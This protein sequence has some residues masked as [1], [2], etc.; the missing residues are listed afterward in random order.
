MGPPLGANSLVNALQLFGTICS[1]DSHLG[2]LI[3]DITEAIT[4]APWAYFINP[5]VAVA[6][7]ASHRLDDGISDRS[8]FAA[9][10]PDIRSHMLVTTNPIDS[11]QKGGTNYPIFWQECMLF[12]LEVH[13]HLSRDIQSPI[14]VIHHHPYRRSPGRSTLR[15][16]QR[17]DSQAC[18]RCLILH[19]ARS[20]CQQ[21]GSVTCNPS[22][23]AK[24]QFGSSHLNRLFHRT[25]LYRHSIYVGFYEDAA[26]F[27][28]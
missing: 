5:E 2:L 25:S 9:M 22:G 28:C 10:S 13:Y 23:G 11:L 21:W 15:D 1:P 18:P 3:I 26:K 7:S 27:V 16:T 14:S 19:S 4:D 12:S 24:T 17:T 8:C 20:D 6:G